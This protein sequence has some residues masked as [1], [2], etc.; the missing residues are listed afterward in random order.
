M[1][2]DFLAL[3]GRS[4]QIYW[5]VLVETPLPWRPWAL[6]RIPAHWATISARTTGKRERV[7]DATDPFNAVLNYAYT[8]L[9][10]ET[11]IACEAVGLD[12]AFHGG[13]CAV[14]DSICLFI[15][16]FNAAH[17][18]ELAPNVLFCRS[19]NVR[20]RLNVGCQWLSPANALKLPRPECVD[21]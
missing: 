11:R 6:S 1:L 15:I 10:V 2:L 7:R 16:A 17:Q 18:Q 19:D 9:E 13:H 4:A 20:S 12:V 3:E 8:L 14:R 21:A 5:D